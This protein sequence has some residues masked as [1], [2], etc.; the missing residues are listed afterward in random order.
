MGLNNW[1]GAL[2]RVRAEGAIKSVLDIGCN[3]C[4]IAGVFSAFFNTRN[5]MCIDANPAL[6]PLMKKSGFAHHV[7]LLGNENKDVTFYVDKN[8]DIS[9][10]CS[11]YLENTEHFKDCKKLILPMK[12]LDDLF[13]DQ[14]FD[15]V[16]IDTQGAEVDILNGGE[17]LISRAKYVMLEASVRLCNFGAPDYVDVLSKMKAL[18]YHLFDVAS[19]DYY[20]GEMNQ[21]DFIFKNRR[22]IAAANAA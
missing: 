16:K 1:Q 7:A 9:T 2:S 13:A 10:G 15:F 8:N 22:F 12:R 14:T 4:E 21:M 19:F 6:L 18:G 5:V 11:I 17:K 3:K 20:Q